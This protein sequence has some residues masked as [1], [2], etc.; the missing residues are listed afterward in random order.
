MKAF[1]LFA[2]SGPIV[3]LT[4]RAS[5]TDPA[6]LGNLRAKGI[7]KFIAFEVPLQLAEARY[8][9]HFQAVLQDLHQT[10][11]LRVLDFDGERA[12]RL[13]KFHELRSAIVYEGNEKS[14]FV[15]D[16]TF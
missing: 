10:D 14:E 13:F 8:C 6:L 2:G 1:M 16:D 7:E 12:L 5:V 15:H 11:D 9:G 4:S 3:I